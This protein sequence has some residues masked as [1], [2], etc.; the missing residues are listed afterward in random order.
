[1]KPSEE[2]RLGKTIIA[3]QERVRLCV[4]KTSAAAQWHVEK[5]ANVVRKPKLLERLAPHLEGEAAQQYLSAL[6]GWIEQTKQQDARC[7]EHWDKRRADYAGQREHLVAMLLRYD[8]ALRSYE[9][10]ARQPSMQLAANSAASSE[11]NAHDESSTRMTEEEYA[12]LQSKI[13]ADLQVMDKARAELVAGHDD[14]VVK[15]VQKSVEKSSEPAEEVAAY[16][17]SGLA[18]AAENFDVR[19]GHRFSTYAQWWIKTA[20]KEKKSWEK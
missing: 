13:E 17:R 9:K 19:Q 15:L 6:P 20:I 8:F 4:C 12:E 3:A 11:D 10:L 5:A 16:A 1:M 14:L 18:K 2:Q 7:G